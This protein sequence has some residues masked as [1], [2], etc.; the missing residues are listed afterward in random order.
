AGL[1][2][3]FCLLDAKILHIADDRRSRGG[4]EAA[5]QA[6]FG[7]AALR[8][9]AGNRVRLVE[10]PAKP[11][12]GSADD[13]VC[14]R[15]TPDQARLRQLALAMPLQKI[16]LGDVQGFARTAVPRYDVDRKIVP[17]G[18]PARG[19]DPPALI[20]KNDIRLRNEVHIRK[21]PTKKIRITPVACRRFAVE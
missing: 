2:Q 13:G 15:L 9:D 16:N 11:I 7:N 19:H 14:M 5:L 17:G 4:R 6:S 12:L 21:A 8:H 3:A 1:E 10:M 20:G 18:G